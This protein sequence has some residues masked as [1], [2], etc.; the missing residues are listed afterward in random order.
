MAEIK[1]DFFVI[2]WFKLNFKLF[3]DREKEPHSYAMRF[4]PPRLSLPSGY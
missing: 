1:V 2:P 4:L 3:Y